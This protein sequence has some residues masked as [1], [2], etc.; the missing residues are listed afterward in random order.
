MYNSYREILWLINLMNAND[1]KTTIEEKDVFD[2]NGNFIIMIQVKKL[3]RKNL[4]RKASGYISFVRGE[5]SI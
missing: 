4:I 2:A 1:N 5:K 3:E